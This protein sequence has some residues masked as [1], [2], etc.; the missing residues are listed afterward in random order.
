[1][2]EQLILEISTKLE[3]LDID[4]KTID[5]IK[6]ALDAYATKIKYNTLLKRFEL[7]EE[8][9]K[10]DDPIKNKT[11]KYIRE[12]LEYNNSLSEAYKKDILE[13]AID[14]VLEDKD[15]EES[16]NDS[17]KITCQKHINNYYMDLIKA[18]NKNDLTLENIERKQY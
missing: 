9:F 1:M 7:L 11:K 4:D 13:Y 15:L 14:K 12:I 18:S 16:I 5:I 8:K 2:D 10:E 17:I 3:E 6:F